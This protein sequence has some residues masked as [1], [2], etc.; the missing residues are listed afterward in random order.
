LRNAFRIYDGHIQDGM[1]AL[2]H[3]AERDRNAGSL[4]FQQ[5]LEGRILFCRFSL[6]NRVPSRKFITET[7]MILNF[8]QAL[9]AVSKSF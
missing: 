2:T 6:V 4:G 7:G 1:K 9:R 5:M 3:R 8:S